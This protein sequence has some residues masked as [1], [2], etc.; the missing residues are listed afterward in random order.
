ML[1][2]GTILEKQKTGRT[3][4]A[5]LLVE[6]GQQLRQNSENTAVSNDD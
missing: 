5:E 2:L 1:T 6:L 3:E 4:L